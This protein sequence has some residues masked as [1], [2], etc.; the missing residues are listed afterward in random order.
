MNVGEFLGLEA[1]TDPNHWRLPV[2][3]GICGGRGALYGGCGLAAMVALLLSKRLV[4]ES[5][6]KTA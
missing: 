2:T 3:D 6:I 5:P 4:A 1:T